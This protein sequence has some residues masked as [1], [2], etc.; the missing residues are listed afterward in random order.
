[1]NR[2]NVGYAP[3]EIALYNDLTIEETLLFHS[4]IHMMDKD[5]FI[6][7]KKWLLNLLQLPDEKRLVGNCSGGQQRRVSLSVALLHSP[8]LL[9]LDEP[10]VGVDPVLRQRIWEYLREIASMGVTILITTHYIEEARQADKI[11]LMRN[12]RL[13]VEG[14]T[15]LVRYICFFPSFV[16]SLL[17]NIMNHDIR[18]P[19]RCHG[20]IRA[21]HVGRRVSEVVQT[22]QE[23]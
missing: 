7:K 15:T 20:R 11:G 18:Q 19:H 17:L 14:K 1:M 4:R 23:R 8:S 9:I 2:F 3:Q 6:K 21:R 5:T 12:G 10:T 22:R 13:L 16:P